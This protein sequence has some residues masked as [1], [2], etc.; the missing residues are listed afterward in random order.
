MAQGFLNCN[1]YHNRFNG[2]HH[3]LECH[4]FCV[5]RNTIL[6]SPRFPNKFVLPLN[7]KLRYRFFLDKRRSTVLLNIVSGRCV[8]SYSRGENFKKILLCQTQ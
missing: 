3:K 2:N 4:V 1:K 6:S 8:H 5:Q 7:V